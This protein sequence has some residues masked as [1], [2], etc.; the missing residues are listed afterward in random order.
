MR[1]GGRF[2]ELD[3]AAR[4]SE[5]LIEFYGREIVLIRKSYEA[6]DD[7]AGGVTPGSDVEVNL[8]PQSLFF[9]EWSDYV[10]LQENPNMGLLR[11]GKYVLVGTLE[12]DMEVGDRFVIN[13]ETYEIEFLHPDVQ[14]EKQGTVIRLGNQG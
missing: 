13:E 5:N 11:T 14:Y 9:G 10:N 12:A 2:S 8:A 7:G 6:E 1:G 4:Q 3:Y